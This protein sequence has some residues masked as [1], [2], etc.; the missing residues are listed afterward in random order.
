ME[1]LADYQGQLSLNWDGLLPIEQAA[2]PADKARRL[3]METL[4]QLRDRGSARIWPLYIQ[5]AGNSEESPSGYMIRGFV[6]AR[7]AQVQV[8]EQALQLTLQPT[9]LITNTALTQVSAEANPYVGKV[10]LIK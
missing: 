8:N 6:A 5:V 2:M 1:D 9:V 10:M 3:M 4:E 7:I